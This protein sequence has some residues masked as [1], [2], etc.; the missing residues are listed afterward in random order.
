MLFIHF[1]YSDLKVLKNHRL[2]FLR[3]K[4]LQIQDNVDSTLFM[5][6]IFTQCNSQTYRLISNYLYLWRTYSHCSK[7]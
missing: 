1:N 5:C 7:I 2:D 6:Y 4:L 3:F